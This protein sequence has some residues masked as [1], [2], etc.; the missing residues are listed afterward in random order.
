MEV[1]PLD[2]HPEDGGQVAEHQARQHAPTHPRLNIIVFVT[3]DARVSN[4]GI[5]VEPGSLQAEQRDSVASV[6]SRQGGYGTNP[7]VLY[8]VLILDGNSGIG[9][10]VS[11]NICYLIC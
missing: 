5:L 7:N 11:S 10:H 9:A 4:P 8:T 6:W 2:E 3:L 1:D